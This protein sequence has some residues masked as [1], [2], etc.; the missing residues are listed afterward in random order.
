MM[1]S[2]QL[3][4]DRITRSYYGYSFAPHIISFQ[5]STKEGAI[6]ALRIAVH[7]ILEVKIQQVAEV[8]CASL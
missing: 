1:F 2:C 3:C 5:A 7:T 4:Y 8:S 6:D